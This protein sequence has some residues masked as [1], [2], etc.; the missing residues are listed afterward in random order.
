MTNIPKNALRLLCCP[1]KTA[2]RVDQDPIFLSPCRGLKQTNFR[3]IGSC[4]ELQFDAVDL[5]NL[6]PNQS[7]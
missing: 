5:P 7:I 4:S 1:P 3:K 2:G 6:S